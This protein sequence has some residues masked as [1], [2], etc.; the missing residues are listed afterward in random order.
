MAWA[1]KAFEQQEVGD[2]MKS[3]LKKVGGGDATFGLKD[4]V[5]TPSNVEGKKREKGF[6]M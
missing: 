6:S 3:E 5:Q 1:A 2:E 4:R